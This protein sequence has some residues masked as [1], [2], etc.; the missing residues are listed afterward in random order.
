MEFTSIHKYLRQLGCFRIYSKLVL[1]SQATILRWILK[2]REKLELAGI[3]TRQVRPLG[4][5]V[6]QFNPNLHDFFV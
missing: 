3:S 1:F 4:G 6:N 2:A 5:N